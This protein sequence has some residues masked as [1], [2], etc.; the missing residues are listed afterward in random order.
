MQRHREYCL[1]L[2]NFFKP[3]FTIIIFTHYKPQIVVAILGLFVVDE[4]D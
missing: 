4:D 3:K 1:T 2:F